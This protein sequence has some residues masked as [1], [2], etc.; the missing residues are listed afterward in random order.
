VAFDR[1]DTSETYEPADD[2]TLDQIASRAS[3]SGPTVTAADIA[4]FNWGTDDP[5]AIDEYLRDELG[6]H[7]RGADKRFVFTTDVEGRGELRIPRPFARAGLPID[8]VHTL[9]V[10]RRTAPP[11]QF[12][13]CASIPGVH[14]EFNKSFIRPTVVDDLKKVEDALGRHPDAKVIVFGHTDQVGPDAYNKRLSERRA[15]SAYAFITNQPDV[16]EELYKHPDEKWGLREIQTILADLGGPYDPGPIDGIDGPRTKAAVRQFQTDHGLAVDGIAGKNTRRELFLAYMT[17]KHDVAVDDARFL[18]P[19][20]IGCGEFNPVV[21]PST[22][23]DKPTRDAENEPNR[24]VT[25]FLFHRD[26]P[27]R[28]PCRLDDLNP[29]THWRQHPLPRHFD[30]FSCSFYDSIAK[31]CPCE[32]GGPPPPPPVA[33]AITITATEAPHFIPELETVEITY[34]ISGPLDQVAGVTLVATPKSDPAKRLV[35]LA[36]SGP[37]Q[38]AGNTHPWDGAVTHADFAGFLSL[39]ASPYEI[40]LELETAAGD[41]IESNRVEV[42][43]LLDSIEIAVEAPAAL[44]LVPR[45][46]RVVDELASEISADGAAGRLVIDSPVFKKATSEM[47]DASSFVQ[48]RSFVRSRFRANQG[49]DVPVLARVFLQPKAGGAAQMHVGALRN[50]ELL[51]DVVLDDDAAYD[52]ALTGRTLHANSRTFVKKVSAYKQNDSEPVGRTAHRHFGGIRDKLANRSADEKHWHSLQGSWGVTEVARKSACTSK[53]ASVSGIDAASGIALNPGRMAGDTHRVRAYVQLADPLDAAD[54]AKLAGLDAAQVSNELSVT[55]WRRIEVVQHHIIGAGTTPLG[56][57]GLTSEYRKAA[58]IMQNKSGVAPTDI[59]ASWKANYRAEVI[60]RSASSDFVKHAALQ[61]PGNFPVAYKTYAQYVAAADA[62][63][64]FFG[65]LWNRIRRFFGADSEEDYV[66]ECRNTALDIIF[67]VAR[68]YPLRPDGLTFFKW[69]PQGS[70]NLETT[71]RNGVFLAGI[72]PSIPN[73][74]GRN[75]AVFFVFNRGS[76]TQTLVHEVGHL[77]FLAHAPGHFNH[78]PGN[79]NDPA[80]NP[81]GYQINAHDQADGCTMSYLPQAQIRGLCGLCQLKLAGW[82]YTKINKDG[83]VV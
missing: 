5:E 67:A 73:F 69:E 68:R 33:H 20:F 4:R 31:N 6:C 57:P 65:R 74:S 82:D 44:N 7:K 83:T 41:R 3:E 80:Q 2:D 50:V 25:F 42:A 60:S 38:A 71:H 15:R 43:V 34:D 59:Q 46:K 23:T 16:W 47:S 61:D 64:G 29:C 63:A 18:D 81:A 30:L 70:Y 58:M 75:K 9:R 54:D 32:G 72:A 76:A 45:H 77:V 27:P 55:P 40:L 28:F 22:A 10:R 8:R 49:P 62:D 53:C 51:W 35:E 13:D 56:V 1:R 24:R 17:G 36:L 12:Q 14:F 21:P 79:P 39:A 66:A 37:F 52:A 26:R 11:P 19:K 48:Y 78:I